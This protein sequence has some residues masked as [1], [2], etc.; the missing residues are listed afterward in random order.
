MTAREYLQEFYP[1]LVKRFVNAQ[2]H[3]QDIEPTLV[4]ICENFAAI[5]TEEKDKEINQL[6]S[7]LAACERFRVQDAGGA[8][9]DLN[10][11]RAKKRQTDKRA[12]SG[13][14][15]NPE[16]NTGNYRRYRKAGTLLS[17]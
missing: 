15:T 2:I 16:R 6:R 5:Q 12:K 14:T 4:K 7:S 13:T 8:I 1:Y 17:A 3:P 9:D 10:N 11:L